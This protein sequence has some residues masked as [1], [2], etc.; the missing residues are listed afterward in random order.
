MGTQAKIHCCNCGNY[1]FVYWA[2]I[3][4]D[5][6]VGCPHCDATMDNDTWEHVVD[7]MGT[8]NELNY[9]SRKQHLEYNEDQFC[10]SIEN[11][12][13]PLEKFRLSE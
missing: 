7:A 8:V 11:V 12:E 13:V 2:G 1:Y 3:R 4:K 5:A 9:I 10:V 6:I